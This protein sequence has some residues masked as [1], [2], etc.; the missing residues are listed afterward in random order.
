M[1]FHSHT[2]SA[3]ELKMLIVP[4]QSK[5]LLTETKLPHNGR[6]VSFYYFFIFILPILVSIF[7]SPP[8]IVHLIFPLF[9]FD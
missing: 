4:N 2:P 9:I 5:L 1:E 8:N 6:Y 3:K 7:L